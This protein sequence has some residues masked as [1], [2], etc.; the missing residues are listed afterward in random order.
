MSP[1]LPLLVALVAVVGGS[2]AARRSPRVW[3]VANLVASLAAL[4]A[5]VSVLATGDTW[6]WRSD[7]A[8]G[9]ESLHVRLDGVSAFFLA[10]LAVL[11]G[12]GSAYSLSY[13]SDAE[14]PRSAPSGR[15]WW[16]AL[17]LFM[18]FV[19]LA[20]PPKPTNTP[21]APVRIRCRAVW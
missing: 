5:A 17:L 14:H 2:A 19:L 8:L 13:W 4:T 7:V 12:A 10:L 18:A 15:I 21:A 20:A 11:G 9:G 3:L 1:G 16:N 6:E